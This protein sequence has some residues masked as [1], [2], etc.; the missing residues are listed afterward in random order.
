MS[1]TINLK[2][3]EVK[4][5]TSES[6]TIIFDK[7][8]DFNYESGQFLTLILTIN[9][10][11]V[12][13]S[14]SFSSSPYTDS[15][16][17]ITI[18]K[19]A[20]G[21][22]S[23]YLFTN[24]YVGLEIKSLP[25]FGAFVANISPSNKRDIVLIAAGSG[26]TPLISIAKSVINQE[27]ESNV[28]LLLGNSNESSII[29]KNEIEKLSADSNG[30]FKAIHSLS[31]PSANWAGNKGRITKDNLNS[32]LSQF[33]VNS[34]QNSEYYLCGPETLMENVI[35]SLTSIGVNANFIKKEKFTAAPTVAHVPS[36]SSSKSTVVAKI[37]NV[38]Y[39]FEVDANETILEAGKNA[40]VDLPCACE[41]GICTACM[42]LCTEGSVDMQGNDTLNKNELS[43]GYVL[44]CC[45]Y[46]NSSKISLVYK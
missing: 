34:L 30:R 9:G 46:A 35:S 11:E 25:P 43:K 44:T 23:N 38:D 39:T 21:L 45:G 24:A 22:V 16:P 32:L 5:E 12:R 17:S 26:I 15:K 20:G 37:K 41:N 42:V 19:I 29:L 36:A 4:M 3:A 33:S 28:F 27:K 40:G 1:N 14:Y 2:I 6:I 13:R 7:P 18:K 31:N 10:E 8:Q